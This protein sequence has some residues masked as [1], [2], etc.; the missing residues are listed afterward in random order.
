LNIGGKNQMIK[1]AMTSDKVTGWS[2]SFIQKNSQHIEFRN[3]F[4]LLIEPFNM[5]IKQFYSPTPL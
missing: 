1:P 3:K 5:A 2:N 4:N